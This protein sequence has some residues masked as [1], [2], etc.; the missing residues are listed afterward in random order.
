MT[1]FTIV[2]EAREKALHMTRIMFALAP[3]YLL[4]VIFAGTPER[5]EV[6]LRI[7][8]IALH[9]APDLRYPLSSVLITVLEASVLGVQSYIKLSVLI[10]TVRVKRSSSVGSRSRS[11]R[12]SSATAITAVHTD[13]EQTNREASQVRHADA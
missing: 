4:E 10:P 13:P 2:D 12:E 11:R 8:F 3:I 9:Y 7:A 1:N 5:S 6:P